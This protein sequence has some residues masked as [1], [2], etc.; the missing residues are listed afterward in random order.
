MYQTSQKRATS[1]QILPDSTKFDL[2]CYLVNTLT[3]RSSD[4]SNPQAPKQSTSHDNKEPAEIDYAEG[5]DNL[6]VEFLKTSHRNTHLVSLGSSIVDLDNP[7]YRDSYLNR[8]DSAGTSKE[9]TSHDNKDSAEIDDAEG[10]DDLTV[11]F[12]KTSYRNTHLVKL[13][14]SIVD[15]DNPE[16]RDSYLNRLDSAGTSKES[17]SHDNK[18]S[19]EIDDA[20]GV[21]DLTVEFLKTSYRNT[22]LVK[23]GSSIV[24][25]DNPE[26]RDSYLNRLDSADI[27]LNGK[28]EGQT[29]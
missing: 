1:N 15:L 13:G 16:Y 23:L 22:H 6:T 10:V 18:D 24:D 11:E 21:D 9:S 26:Y 12:L 4:R 7:E 14:S 28:E 29:E 5:V 19:A 25:L 2:D 8:L 27:D 20:E 17:T 3:M